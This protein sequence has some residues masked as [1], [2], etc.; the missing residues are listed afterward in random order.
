MR[1][2]RDAVIGETDR[3]AFGPKQC[4]I[5][6]GKRRARV[7]QDTDEIF[8]GQRFQLDADRQ[9][10][11][12]FREQ[13]ARLGNVERARCNEQDVVGLH[14]AIFGRDRRPLDQRQ[15]VTLDAFTAD[16]PAADVADRDL[17][18][19]VEEYDAI[20]F[21][22]GKR[23]AAEFFL[24]EALVGFFLDQFGPGRRHGHLPALQLIAA[25]FSHHLAKVDHA[26]VAATGDFEGQR[27][28]GFE[29]DLDFGF[30]KMPVVKA[31]S[32]CS[33]RGFGCAFARQRIEQTAHG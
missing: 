26:D 7:L 21:G 8:F 19:L 17:V 32:K 9:A 1:D 5:L 13:V 23:D 24:I 25:Q 14:R 30:G 31:L 11:L 3:H 16:R 18:D 4:L 12:Q 33:A 10:A 29:F 6:I 28:G 22:V 15:K 27:R 20:G 2:C